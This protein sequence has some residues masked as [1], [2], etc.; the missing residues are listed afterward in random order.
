VVQGL[1][2][3]AELANFQT[4]LNALTSGQARYT[5]ALSHYDPVPPNTQAALA[6]AYKVQDEAE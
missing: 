3:L 4:R 5:L 1:A 6:A 2:P